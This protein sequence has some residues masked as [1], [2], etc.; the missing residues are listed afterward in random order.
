ME[1]PEHSGQGPVE[2]QDPVKVEAKHLEPV[3]CPLDQS[4]VPLLAP[5]TVGLLPS[6]LGARTQRH[7]ENLPVG[8][9]SGL[10]DHVAP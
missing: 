5:P 8:R 4:T 10:A 3:L 1:T 9:H 6:R 7:L 2:P